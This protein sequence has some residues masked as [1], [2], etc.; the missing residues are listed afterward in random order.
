MRYLPFPLTFPDY[1][2][3]D[4]I[5][6]WLESYVDIM[7]VDFWTRTS[8][9]GADYDKASQ[10]WTARISPEG[11]ARSLRP[12]HIVLA[13]SV[14]GTP[15]IPAIDGIENFKGRVLHSSRFAAGKEWAGRP[16]AVFGTGTSAHDI[17]Q[18]LQAVGA[19]VTMVQRSPTMV[20]NVEPAQLYDKTYLGDGP[21][22]AV[23]DILNSG[24]PLPV[25]KVAH[26][27]MTDEVKRL[28]APAADAVGAC[29]FSP[30]I[31]RG[32]HRLA[33]EVSHPRRRLFQ[34]RRLRIDRRRQ[35]QTGAGRRYRG[36]SA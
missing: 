6:S 26:K 34:R 16:V 5:A 13:T 35:N 3:K 10:R 25:M 4:Q 17:C 12:K 31:R 19:D 22:I 36:L 7:E 9:D 1:I 14:S 8:F 29:W 20:V 24:V 15:N 18:E 27:L 32:R 2:P 33:A 23:R 28:D 21:P 11:T 30:R